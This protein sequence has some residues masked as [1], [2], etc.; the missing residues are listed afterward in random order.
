MVRLMWNHGVAGWRGGGK[1]IGLTL[2]TRKERVT[3]RGCF[4]YLKWWADGDGGLGVWSG[5]G[6]GLGWTGLG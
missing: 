5:L 3:K 2:L 4:Y 6:S 1:S